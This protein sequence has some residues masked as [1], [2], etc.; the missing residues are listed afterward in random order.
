[1]VLGENAEKMSKS[2]GNVINPDDIIQEY[3]A[4]ALRLFEVFMGEFDQPI[5][6]STNGLVGMSRFLQRVW[7]MQE[8][9][10]I[11]EPEAETSRLLQQTVKEVGD[12]L[13]AMK[14]NTALAALMEMANH[15]SRLPGISG[16][17]WATFLRLLSP[18]APHVCEELWGRLHGPGLV[19]EQSWP[20]YDQ[21]QA[22]RQTLEIPVQV[23]GKLR[24]RITLSPDA[25]D[26]LIKAHALEAVTA[27][28]ESK[29][30]GQVIVARKGSSIMV[31]VVTRDRS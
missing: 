30:V 3:G 13:E 11:Q 21:S 28:T 29:S 27:Y 9:V 26:D 19:C 2:R 22:G 14:F 4:D 1:M 20:A 24:K 12:R 25:T 23:D 7:T 6:W 8:K 31:N 16:E 18:F 15:F 10:S 5:P 17:H